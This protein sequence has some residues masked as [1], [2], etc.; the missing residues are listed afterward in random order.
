MK[1]IYL[2]IGTGWDGAVIE[3]AFTNQKKRD[4]RIKALKQEY[5]TTDDWS[6]WEVA[7]IVLNECVADILMG[8]EPPK[9]GE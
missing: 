7:S 9:E 2:I 8:I 5:P 4:I 3:S 1:E 6:G